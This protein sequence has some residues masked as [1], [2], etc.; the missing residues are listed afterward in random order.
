MEEIKSHPK[1]ITVRLSN[2]D[3]KYSRDFLVY[4][5]NIFLSPDDPVLKGMINKTIEDFKGVPDH[6]TVRIRMD[7]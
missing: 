1:E 6:C 3:Q 4:E 7:L 2:E 5:D